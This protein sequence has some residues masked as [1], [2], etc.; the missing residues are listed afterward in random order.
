[1]KIF[2]C[3]KCGAKRISTHD[4]NTLECVKCY[5]GHCF[6]I[7]YVKPPNIDLAYTL[8]SPERAAALKRIREEEL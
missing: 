2:I 8:S 6:A 4:G 7:D 1:M 3:D 5:A